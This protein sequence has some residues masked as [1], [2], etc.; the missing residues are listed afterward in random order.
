M[1]YTYYKMSL[2]VFYFPNI[3][4]TIRTISNDSVGK[5]YPDADVKQEDQNDKELFENDDIKCVG[6]EELLEL[7]NKSFSPPLNWPS[8]TM[9]T[10]EMMINDA[11]NDIDLQRNCSDE[12]TPYDPIYDSMT[13][14]PLIGYQGGQLLIGGC[15]RFNNDSIARDR[16]QLEN[17]GKMVE[18]NIGPSFEFIDKD[19]DFSSGPPSL[20]LPDENDDDND[21]L[22]GNIYGDVVSDDAGIDDWS[23]S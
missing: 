13:P 18:P 7:E 3:Q 4:G 21:L 23:S 11:S 14:P 15:N 16:T 10:D 20:A 12:K 2:K 9:D 1:P 8:S 6:L 22:D 17:N 19:S 5:L